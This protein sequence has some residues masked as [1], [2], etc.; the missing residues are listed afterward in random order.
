M[1]RQIEVTEVQQESA[2]VILPSDSNVS[3]PTGVTVHEQ[4]WIAQDCLFPL[5]G[6]TQRMSW[7]LRSATGAVIQEGGV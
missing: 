2:A 6:S 7:N 1:E 4:F 5:N 3:L